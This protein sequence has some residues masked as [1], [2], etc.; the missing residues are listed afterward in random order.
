MQSVAAILA[1]LSLAAAFP[2]DCPNV[3]VTHS[4]VKDGWKA[5]CKGLKKDDDAE[6]A[7]ACKK[8]CY[9]NVNCSVWQWVEKGEGDNAEMICWRGNDV[10]GCSEAHFKGDLKEGERIQ[11]GAIKIL[12]NFTNGTFYKGLFDVPKQDGNESVE[13]ERCKLACN[14]DI[15]CTV[16]LYN[17]D[18]CSVERAP[19]QAKGDL[20]TEGDLATSVVAGQTIEHFCPFWVPPE[21]EEGLP[22]PWIAGGVGA[23]VVVVGG[24]VAAFSKAKKAK[25][26]KKYK[27]AEEEELVSDAEEELVYDEEEELE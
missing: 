18:G 6:T 7:M 17:K 13:I 4:V 15:R 20:V 11:H 3:T 14:T 2:N 16:W 1:F 5:G 8:S 19:E 26:K 23:G 22:W 9:A 27:P 25:G 24:I 12:S 21:E 10:H